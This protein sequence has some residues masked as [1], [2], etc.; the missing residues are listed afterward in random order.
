MRGEAVSKIAIS[1]QNG[2]LFLELNEIMYG[3]ASNNYT[4]IIVTDGRTLI[5]SKT[6]RDVQRVLEQ[7][8][9]LRIHRQYIIN[10]NYVTHFNRNDSIVTMDNL[11]T[12]PVARNQKD[13]LIEKYRWL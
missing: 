7:S 1:S 6:L 2:I 8:H 12:L 4:K 3:E 13:R 9:F 11:T 5:I 10:L